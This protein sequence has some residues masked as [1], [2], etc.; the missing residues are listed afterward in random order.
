MT[1]CLG[2]CDSK[3]K[4]K[5]S[6]GRSSDVY[7]LYTLIIICWFS[8]LGFQL[9]DIIFVKYMYSTVSRQIKMD[10]LYLYLKVFLFMHR[11]LII[12]CKTQA[13]LVIF[14]NW[15]AKK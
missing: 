1:T 11:N 13:I 7:Y 15:A 12:I 9:F 2:I 4:F 6:D 10:I 5:L 8:L 3:N 14:E